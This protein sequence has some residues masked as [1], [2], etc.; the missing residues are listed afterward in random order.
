MQLTIT[1]GFLHVCLQNSSTLK[2]FVCYVTLRHLWTLN[3]LLGGIFSGVRPCIIQCHF[4]FMLWHNSNFFRHVWEGTATSGGIGDLDPDTACCGFDCGVR[5]FCFSFEWQVPTVTVSGRLRLKGL[6][7]LQMGVFEE[8][9][10]HTPGM[11]WVSYSA[12]FKLPLPF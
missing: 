2:C 8:K 4:F 5:I 11:H 9:S 12:Q 7:P 1:R 6:P 3:K 10:S